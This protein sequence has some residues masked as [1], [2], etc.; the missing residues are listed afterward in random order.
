[1]VTVLLLTA[2]WRDW[3]L[4]SRTVYGDGAA[5]HGQLAGLAVEVAHCVW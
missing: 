5:T 3:L 1:M 2:S 4:R